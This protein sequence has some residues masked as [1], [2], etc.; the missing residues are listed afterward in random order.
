[1]DANKVS[2]FFVLWRSGM[3]YK[4]GGALSGGTK[5][6]PT[7]GGGALAGQCSI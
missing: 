1:M 7:M 3:A 2:I 4:K 5:S 6:S